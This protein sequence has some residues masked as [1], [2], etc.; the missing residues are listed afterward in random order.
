MRILVTPW[1]DLTNH[2]SQKWSCS[3]LHGSGTG[4]RRQI[5]QPP[6][7]K[8]LDF[9]LAGIALRCAWPEGGGSAIELQEKRIRIRPRRNNPFRLQHVSR[10]VLGTLTKGSTTLARLFLRTCLNEKRCISVILI[11]VTS[12]QDLRSET[13]SYAASLHPRLNFRFSATLPELWRG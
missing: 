6:I 3:W 2:R 5:C 10:N 12:Q 13:N 1:H 7:C 8:C 9:P 4:V 11:S